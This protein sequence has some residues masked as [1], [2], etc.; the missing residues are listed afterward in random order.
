MG[1]RFSQETYLPRNKLDFK[2]VI[3]CSSLLLF[4]MQL[5][6]SPSCIRVATMERGHV[7]KRLSFIMFARILFKIL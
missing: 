6:T 1:L 4:V 7:T 3:D 2:E 5:Q